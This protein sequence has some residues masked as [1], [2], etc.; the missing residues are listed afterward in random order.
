M[1]FNEDTAETRQKAADSILSGNGD[2]S[3][4]N[5]LPPDSEALTRDCLK[6]LTHDEMTALATLVVNRGKKA[7][8]DDRQTD[9][10]QALESSLADMAALSYGSVYLYDDPDDDDFLLDDPADFSGSTLMF[11]SDFDEQVQYGM[12]QIVDLLEELKGPVFV[13]E[14]AEAQIAKRYGSTQSLPQKET[15]IKPDKCDHDGLV[16]LDGAVLGYKRGS[17]V[18]MDEDVADQIG[19]RK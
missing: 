16:A 13:H 4:P 9:A 10:L 1:K 14:L 8:L 11:S 12:D 3:A 7:E 2:G 5:P 15:V 18:F 6:S 17:K 19:W